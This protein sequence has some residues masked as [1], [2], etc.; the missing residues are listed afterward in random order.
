[1]IYNLCQAIK[2]TLEKLQN[3]Y[4]FLIGSRNERNI[5]FCIERAYKKYQYKLE[6]ISECSLK[7][8]TKQERG[9]IYKYIR[10]YIKKKVCGINVEV[11]KA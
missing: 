8:R 6:C 3:Y 7:K 9:N 1:M 10:G 2:R 11:C 4:L 5:C